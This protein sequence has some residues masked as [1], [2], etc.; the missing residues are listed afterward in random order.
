[1]QFT[2]CSLGVMHLAR[3]MMLH[4]KQFQPSLNVTSEE[5]YCVAAAGLL[6]CQSQTV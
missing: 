4:F 5:V 3:K 6:V 2:D 1:M